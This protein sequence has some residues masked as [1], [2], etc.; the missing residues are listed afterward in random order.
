MRRLA[1]FL[2][3]TALLFTIALSAA[4]VSGK[5]TGQVPRRGG[6]PSESTFTFKV[7]GDKLTGT[8]TTPQGEKP[9]LEGK[10]SGDTISFK[11]EDSQRGPSA[12]QGTVAGDEIKFT[13]TS[14]GGQAR[15]FAAKRAK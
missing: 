15:P 4:D 10:V 3:I 5:W 13:R 11:V 6:E 7:D 8:V 12:Y 2:S 9:V 14:S 1:T